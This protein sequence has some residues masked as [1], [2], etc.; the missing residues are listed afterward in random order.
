M[1]FEEGSLI[2]SLIEEHLER[3]KADIR[4]RRK[5]VYRQKVIEN[6]IAFSAECRQKAIE[7]D[8]AFSAK[9]NLPLPCYLL[10]KTKKN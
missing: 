10:E 1:F 6:D 4:L 8:I 2:G 3:L 7:S 9:Y 5:E